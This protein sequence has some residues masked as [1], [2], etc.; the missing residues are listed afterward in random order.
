MDPKDSRTVESGEKERGSEPSGGAGSR[1]EARANHATTS[2]SSLTQTL[3]P[4][5][6]G[7]RNDKGSVPALWILGLCLGLPGNDLWV[8][9]CLKE[10]G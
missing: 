2:Y 6:S 9:L 1:P 7:L 5:L 10:W 4:L 3:L 8:L